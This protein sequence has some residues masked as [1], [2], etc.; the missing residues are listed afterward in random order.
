MTQQLQQVTVRNARGRFMLDL[1][2]DAGQLTTMTPEQWEEEQRQLRREQRRRKQTKPQLL[3][4][5]FGANRESSSSSAVDSGMEE[6]ADPEDDQ[7]PSRLQVVKGTVEADSIVVKMAEG[8]EKVRDAG[9]PGWL[10]E[11]FAK[12]V[13]KASPKGLEFARYSID[14][15]YLRNWLYVRRQWGEERADQHI[16]SYAKK[17][18]AEYLVNEEADEAAAKEPKEET[19]GVFFTKLMEQVTGG[20]SKLKKKKQGWLEALD[21]KCRE[22]K[23]KGPAMMYTLNKRRISTTTAAGQR[24]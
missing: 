23:E 19:E 24:E 12:A 9:M 13:Y 1:L 22:E 4:T 17:I 5:F 3:E 2:R 15:H 18:I 11:V 14:Y 6:G 21:E 20:K 7:G 8:P 16:P 10:G